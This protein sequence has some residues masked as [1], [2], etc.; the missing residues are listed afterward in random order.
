MYTLEAQ[1]LWFEAVEMGPS[2]SCFH[3][4][5]SPR[6]TPAEYQGDFERVMGEIKAAPHGC[7]TAWSHAPQPFVVFYG[8]KPGCPHRECSNFF[9]EMRPFEFHIPEFAR[10]PQ[11]PSTVLC[12]S[13]E[14]AIMLT[15]AALM[16]DVTTFKRIAAE[17]EPMMCKQFGREV[18]W[19]D[20]QQRKWDMHVHAVAFE[21]VLAKFASD[22]GLADELLATNDR[23][24][25]EATEK[26]R[27]WAVGLKVDDE[28]VHDPQQW[29][30]Q[31]ILGIALMLVREELRKRPELIEAARGTG[32]SR[33]RWLSW[34]PCAAVALLACLVAWLGHRTGFEPRWR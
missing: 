9:T 3:G 25:V 17:A 31:N 20:A 1:L 4:A 8:H 33:A 2:L 26:D 24:I 13:S 10:T 15:K 28:A 16:E 11:I 21:A 22:A 27:I 29:K 32:G 6:K 23:V 7:S 19:G 5:M 30:G 12:E 18:Q 14:K 34:L